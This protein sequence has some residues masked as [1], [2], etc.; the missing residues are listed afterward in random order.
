[1]NRTSELAIIAA[2]QRLEPRDRAVLL[3]RDALGFRAGEVA[4]MLDTSEEWVDEALLR[5]RAIF[6]E[7]L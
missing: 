5:A 6:E 2:L 3:L 4:D 1:V 7:W